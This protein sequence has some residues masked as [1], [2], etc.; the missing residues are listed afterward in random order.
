[1]QNP[2]PI[3]SVYRPKWG[4]RIFSLFFPIF[5]GCAVISALRDYIHQTE[6]F[7]PGV[8]IVGL[9][10]VI[11]GT[12]MA[13]NFFTSVV[14]F[15]HDSIEHR[16]LFRRRSLPLAAIGGRREYMTRDSDGVPTYYLRL[17][18]ND[19]RLPVIEFTRTFAL[20]KAFFRWFYSLPELNERDEPKSSF[21]I[22]R[23][24]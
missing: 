4:W 7:K 12:G 23:S 9:L 24:R 11:I 17:I 15:T 20:D 22:F 14:R 16:T 2:P 18:P 1:M 13:I 8:L 10:F 6:V 3:L 5:G 19:H 21:S